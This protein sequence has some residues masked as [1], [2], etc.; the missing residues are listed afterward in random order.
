MISDLKNIYL[1]HFR[2]P[3]VTVLPLCTTVID[4]RPHASRFVN[5]GQQWWVIA[6]S[7]PWLKGKL[8]Y[9]IQPRENPFS[10]NCSLEFLIVLFKMYSCGVK[11]QN[12]KKTKKT[13]K[14]CVTVHKF[15]DL[16]V[17][18]RYNIRFLVFQEKVT[19]STLNGRKEYLKADEGDKDKWEFL[20]FANAWTPSEMVLPLEGST[21]NAKTDVF[22][23]HV[24]QQE[25]FNRHL[26]LSLFKLALTCRAIEYKATG[27][28]IINE[29]NFI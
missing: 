18:W 1:P 15:V 5:I 12:C 2:W 20:N 10:L 13:T 3:I 23:T 4:L 29:S 19:G 8:L 24:S 26:F 11:K 14:K 16:S 21:G 25:I 27:A 6:G 9:D 22:F 17:K 28:F 7:F